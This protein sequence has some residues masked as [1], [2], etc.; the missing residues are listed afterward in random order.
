MTSS[1][2]E[3]KLTQL[4]Q[5]DLPIDINTFINLFWNDK[6]FLKRYLIDNLKD[7]NVSIGDWSRDN[8][9]NLIRRLSCDHPSK[10]SFPGLPIPSHTRTTKAQTL[11]V[12]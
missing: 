12:C 3:L 6:D 4:K 9:G 7:L 2:E 5:F 10:W 8:S 11:Q 1:C